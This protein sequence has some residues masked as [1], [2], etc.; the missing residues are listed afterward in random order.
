M[1][2][3]RN[4][5]S[6]YRKTWFYYSF[7]LESRMRQLIDPFKYF[8]LPDV[9]QM[10][11]WREYVSTCTKLNL[12]SKH[13]SLT[14]ESRRQNIESDSLP[15]LSVRMQSPIAKKIKY[16]TKRKKIASKY[17]RSNSIQIIRL[18]D[19]LQVKLGKRE[20]SRITLNNGLL[21]ILLHITVDI[22]CIPLLNTN[23]QQN[24]VIRHDIIN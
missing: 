14:T 18:S 22:F 6:F 21:Q 2:L 9:S 13:Y 4:N 23:K 17:C 10:R 19:G 20:W 15:L 3:S 16:P 24:K 8:L 11:L 5:F 12:W 1:K 7:K